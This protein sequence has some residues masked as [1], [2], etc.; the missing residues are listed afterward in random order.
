MRV[1]AREEVKYASAQLYMLPGMLDCA[2]TSQTDDTEPQKL[3]VATADVCK[4]SA[5]CL[6]VNPTAAWLSWTTLLSKVVPKIQQK[7]SG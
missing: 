3:I 2:H 4:V 1:R 6:N 7:I 5:W